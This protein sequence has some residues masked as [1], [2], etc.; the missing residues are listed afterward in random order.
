MY[1]NKVLAVHYPEFK[2]GSLYFGEYLK[3]FIKDQTVLDA[4]CGA[5]GLISEFK[6]LAKTLIGVDSDSEALSN[7]H[8]VD[9]KILGDLENLPQQE[10]SI[11]IVSCEFVLEHLRSPERVF[12]EFAR[13]LKPGGRLIFLTPNHYN[14]IMI[15]SRIT[16]LTIHHL[17]RKYFLKRTE[18]PY[19]TYYAANSY[20]TIIKLGAEV[21][22]VVGEIKRAGNPEYLCFSKLTVLPSVL[23]EKII[24][25]S[26]LDFLKMYLVG[27]LVKS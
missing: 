6:T 13:V 22:L 2:T 27:Y 20:N 8:I 3:R 1:I 5:G 19:K 26:S 10:N 17:F 25:R 12:A 9:Q 14:P 16:P 4:G 24:N 18:K 21:G 23:L 11:D 15:L 7:N